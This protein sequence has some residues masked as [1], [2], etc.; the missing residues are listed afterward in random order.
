MSACAGTPEDGPAD[1][2][3]ALI[4][5]GTTLLTFPEPLYDAVLDA[6]ETAAPGR[7]DELSMSE[8]CEG[9]AFRA[10]PDLQLSLGGHSI[11][12]SRDVYMMPTEVA[13]DGYD[14]FGPFIMP[15]TTEGIACVPMFSAMPLEAT[16]V[17]PLVILGMPFLRQYATLFD[18][19]NKSMSVARIDAT[20]GAEEALC[21]GC[22]SSDDS[23]VAQGSVQAESAAAV[24]PPRASAFQPHAVG[25]ADQSASVRAASTAMKMENAR[26]PWWA[27]DPKVRARPPPPV[28]I[29]RVRA[30]AIRGNTNTTSAMPRHWR[31][32]ES[33][34][35]PRSAPW[36]LVV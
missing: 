24:P 2:C 17:G 19:S 3:G 21:S 4:D 35:M 20:G 31:P 32:P 30:R 28:P 13:Y 16:N 6:I 12:L 1:T 33:T 9:E 29:G 27:V 34:P 10:L 11:T 7:M 15:V 22:A 26:L 25:A 36:R 14:T 18:R 23:L 8:T 5:S